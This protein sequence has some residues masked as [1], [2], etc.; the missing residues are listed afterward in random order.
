MFGCGGAAVFEL[1]SGVELVFADGADFDANGSVRSFDGYV[2]ALEAA[3]L[4]LANAQAESGGFAKDELF[5]RGAV[6]WIAEDGE[7]RAGASFCLPRW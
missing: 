5:E 6:G 4:V 7:E 3:A 1:G 2:A